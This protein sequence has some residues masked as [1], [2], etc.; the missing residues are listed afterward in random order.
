V[1]KVGPAREGGRR[2][3]RC[4]RKPIDHSCRE[5][6]ARVTLEQARDVF[7][8][9]GGQKT[10]V[11]FPKVRHQSLVRTGPLWTESVSVFLAKVASAP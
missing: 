4:R 8:H 7:E 6:D 1:S 10:F 9:L 5:K 3:T 2:P 11:T